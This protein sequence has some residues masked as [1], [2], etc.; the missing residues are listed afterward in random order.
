MILQ[1]V[2]W[3]ALLTRIWSTGRIP[4]CFTLF[5]LMWTIGSQEL[6][7]PKTPCRGP[8]ALGFTCYVWRPSKWYV[9]MGSDVLLKPVIGAAGRCFHL[10]CVAVFDWYVPIG[11]VLMLSVIEAAGPLQPCWTSCLTFPR[12]SGLSKILQVDRTRSDL[13]PPKSAE[14]E[15]FCGPHDT[16]VLPR[17]TVPATSSESSP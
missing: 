2:A 4:V 1:R 15:L 7:R 5:R 9:P 14:D 11:S 6:N 10:L 17:L 8:H 16:Q 3:S 13:L 12:H